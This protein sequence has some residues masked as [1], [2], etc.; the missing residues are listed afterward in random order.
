MLQDIMALIIPSHFSSLPYLNAEQPVVDTTFWL[1]HW[2][3]SIS[4]GF[5]FLHFAK[6]FATSNSES[7]LALF[8][9]LLHWQAAKA[10]MNP[11]RLAPRF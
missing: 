7:G 8:W 2:L 11:C 10:Q 6:V 1:K 4:F 3:K 5:N 9:Y